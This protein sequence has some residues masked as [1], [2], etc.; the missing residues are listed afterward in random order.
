MPQGNRFRHQAYTS[1]APTSPH[2]LL[3]PPSCPLAESEEFRHRM[4]QVAKAYRE[5]GVC[6]I[7]LVHGSFVGAD[8]LGILSAL[9]RVY[10]KAQ[11][12]FSEIAK[13]AVDQLAG[14]GGN[15]TGQFAKCFEE[16]LQTPGEPTIPVRRFLWSS[17]NNH[18]GRADGAIRLLNKIAGADL[19]ADGRILFW[20]HSHAGNVFALLTNLIAADAETRSAFFDAAR[21]YY[22]W[23][24]LGVIDIPFWS[25][26]E[27]ILAE[28][29]ELITN[30]PLDFVTFGTPI[31]YG[32]DS[33]G[34]DHLL[35]FVNHKPAEG[36]PNY[37]AP[38]PPTPQ[39]VISAA[40][41]DYV[42]HCGIAGTNLMPSLFSWRSCLAD[43]RLNKLLQQDI[44]A[45]DLPHHLKCGC[46]VPN[47]GTTLLVDYG[48]AEGSL[49]EHAAGH[50]VYTRSQWLL[51][52]A[53]E[54]ARRFYNAGSLT[55]V[56]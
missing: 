34:Y 5:A 44:H 36:L 43:R 26:V 50:A 55:A 6:A 22:R 30:H 20:G 54:V 14:E 16:A 19:P 1:T 31:R 38:F 15:Y 33:D 13:Q 45:R 37:Q 3:A 10:P 32:W 24:Y 4:Q 28:Q 12:F 21:I 52:H 9:G 8:A 41:G 46:R 39:Q 35:H 23:P 40:D 11:S 56:A 29:P 27:K 17:Q 49:P 53:E 18:I 47:E 25:R 42:Q 2:H 7:Y 48:P 51:F